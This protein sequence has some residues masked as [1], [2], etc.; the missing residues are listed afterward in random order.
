MEKVKVVRK[1]KA[2]PD[3]LWE[4]Y[5]DHSNWNKWAGISRST[6]AI[7]GK[8]DK[9]GTGAVRC[10]GS[11]GIYAYE[12]II[13]FEPPV[14]MTYTVIKGG[15]PQKNHLGEV[16]LEQHKNQTILTWKYRFDLK[17]PIPGLGFIM[18]RYVT[19]LFRSMLDGLAIYKFP[20]KLFSA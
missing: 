13:D 15:L 8:P 11:F 19:R 2:Q 9:N 1:F 20:D 5:T 10:F 7:E 16:L 4:T 12:K 6:L 18:N 3:E 14:R 17:I